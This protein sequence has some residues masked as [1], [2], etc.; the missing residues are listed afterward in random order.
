MNDDLA[1]RKAG[2]RTGAFGR[3]G[4]DEPLIVAALDALTRVWG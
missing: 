4:L 1:W 2:R 3:D